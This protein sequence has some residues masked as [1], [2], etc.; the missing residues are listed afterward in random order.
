MHNILRVD[1]E[2]V[3]KDQR[4]VIS[5]D[6]T[7]T[8]RVSLADPKTARA[9]VRATFKR[10]ESVTPWPSES[11]GPWREWIIQTVRGF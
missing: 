5:G 9:V 11:V 10:F 4:L 8:V 7:A 2:I 3:N 6:H 1:M